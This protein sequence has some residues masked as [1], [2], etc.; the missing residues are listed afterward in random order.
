MSRVI[1]WTEV[2]P[3]NKTVIDLIV[4]PAALLQLCT[5]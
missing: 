4:R 3:S 2:K 1:P 5:A